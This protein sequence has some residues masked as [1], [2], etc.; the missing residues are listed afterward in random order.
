M[1][2]EGLEKLDNRSIDEVSYYSHTRYPVISLMGEKRRVVISIDKGTFV[3]LQVPVVDKECTVEIKVSDF[4]DGAVRTDQ[5]G[6][7]LRVAKNESHYCAANR[8]LTL[9]GQVPV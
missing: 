1:D 6:K 3:Y 8:R 5:G 7:L 4:V 2:N 9:H